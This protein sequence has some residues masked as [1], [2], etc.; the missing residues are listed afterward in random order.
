MDV[1]LEETKDGGDAILSGNDLKTV[2]GWQNM[3]YLASFGGNVEQDTTGPKEEGQQ[4]FDWWGNNLLFT[5]DSGIQFNSKLERTLNTVPLS[6]AGLLKI[7]DAVKSDLDFMSSFAS[8]TVEVSIESANTILIYV[9]IQQPDNQS[10]SSITY[11]W[12]STK[13]ELTITTA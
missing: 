8:I 9:T 6:S 4:A 12:D 11:L 5:D 1:L 10:S 2:N 13:Q 7:K 3:P